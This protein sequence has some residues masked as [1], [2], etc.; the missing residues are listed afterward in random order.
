[1]ADRVFKCRTL[2]YSRIWKSSKQTGSMT[3]ALMRHWKL[4]DSLHNPPCANRFSTDIAHFH[5][6]AVHMAYVAPWSDRIR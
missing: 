6:Y 3:A 1:M 4:T 5:H 2:L